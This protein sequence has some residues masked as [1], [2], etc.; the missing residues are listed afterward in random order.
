MS[1]SELTSA[2]AEKIPAA[3]VPRVDDI[4]KLCLTQ[5]QVGC[6]VTHH[7]GPGIYIRECTIRRG[8]FVTGKLHRFAHTNN[9]IQGRIM[10][11][12]NGSAFHQ[13]AAPYKYNSPAGQKMGE[14]LEDVVWQ[15]I[16]ATAITDIEELERWLFK[17]SP[18]FL[19]AAEAVAR[20]QIELRKVDQE[21]FFMVLD[22]CGISPYQ[23][24]AESERIDDQIPMPPGYSTMIRRSAIEGQGV[25]L[26][27]PANPG[28]P[29]A[30]GRIQG[31]RTPV[32]RFVNHSRTPNA[33]YIEIAG[34]AIL[35]ATAHINPYC[36]ELVPGDEV[37]V[38]Y[39]QALSL[40]GR[41]K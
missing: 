1:S 2:E 20:A 21:D 39:R 4:E 30:P 10:M 23:A 28:D 24:R 11:S 8:V 7:F 26:Q 25:F 13:V 14:A 15:N 31:K 3:K 35:V 17:P 22:E 6:E 40:A 19:N 29:I 32:G 12:E 37:T 27:L 5:T 34:D 33:K 38:D 9:M 16:Y 36:N 41:L 18:A